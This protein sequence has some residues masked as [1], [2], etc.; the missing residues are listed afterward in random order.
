MFLL[1]IA[2]LWCVAAIATLTYMTEK[3][4]KPWKW[5]FY[6]MFQ[7]PETIAIGWIFRAAEGDWV[8]I[9]VASKNGS[10]LLNGKP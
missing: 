4:S 5:K 9:S 10:L 8:S 2:D 7:V 6:Q 3:A 1:R